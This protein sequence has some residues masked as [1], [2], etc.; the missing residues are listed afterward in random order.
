MDL[1]AEPKRGRIRILPRV[2]VL[3][4][5]FVLLCLL[6]AVKP[7]AD[8]V[9]RIQFG[10]RV[11]QTVQLK[12]KGVN[13]SV[14]WR[15]AS[16]KKRV[17]LKQNGLLRARRSGKVVIKVTYNGVTYRFRTR[18][19]GKKKNQSSM[20]RTVELPIPLVSKDSQ[21][22]TSVP[23]AGLATT[24]GKKVSEDQII[25]IGDSRFEG[26]KGVVGGSATWITAV[27]EGIYWL[28]DSVI[29]RLD[30]MD[31]NGKAVVINLGINDLTETST[32]ISVLNKLGENLRQRGASV[33][34]MT[35]NPVDEGLEASYG[36]TVKNTVVV[37]FICKLAKS[38]TG[39]GIIDTYDYLVDHGFKATDGIHYA[40]DTYKVIYQVLCEAIRK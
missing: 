32:Y 37:D 19:R 38:L 26:M 40:A 11:G 5:L 1:L 6:P 34:F 9:T 17:K 27:G 24:A 8:T 3:F 39:Y 21:A 22:K 31:V 13:E 30:S 7:K 15:V 16:G 2:G 4:S 12:L 33:Y 35:V 18:I 28:R 29:P 20:L 10:M 14:I 36:Y 25:M 23:R